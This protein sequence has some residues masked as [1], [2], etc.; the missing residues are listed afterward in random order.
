[1]PLPQNL[2]RASQAKRAAENARILNAVQRDE[3]TLLTFLKEHG[4]AIASAIMLCMTVVAA[5]WLTTL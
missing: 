4:S 2:D 5:Y 1:M 3:W